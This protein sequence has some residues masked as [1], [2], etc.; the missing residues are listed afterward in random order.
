MYHKGHGSEVKVHIKLL[1]FLSTIDDPGHLYYLA[2]E[3][4]ISLVYYSDEEK[5]IS[6]KIFSHV[7]MHVAFYPCHFGE[8]LI[9]FQQLI[10]HYFEPTCCWFSYREAHEVNTCSVF[11]FK[12]VRPYEVYT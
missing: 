1:F 2:I 8:Q 4:F 3:Y 7:S 11:A 5:T 9:F 10:F 6:G 12:S